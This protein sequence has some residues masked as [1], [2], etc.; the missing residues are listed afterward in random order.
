MKM[1][2][3]FFISLVIC[4]LLGKAET[5]TLA[6]HNLAPY[7]SYA[8]GAIMSTVANEEFTGIAVDRV[9]CSF[10]K[11]G[12]DLNILV[13][14]WAR[15]QRLAESAEVDGFFA[16]SQNNYRDTYAVKTNII[17][18][19]KWK[20]YWL[21]SNSVDLS[22][23][24]SDTLENPPRIGAFLG[25]NMSRWL[26]DNGY[27]IFSRPNTTE[28]LAQLLIKKRIDVF[29]ANNLVAEEIF[30]QMGAADQISSA[31]VKDKPLYLY[32]VKRNL[33]DHPNFVEDFN[34]ELANCYSEEKP[35]EAN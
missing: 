26:E 20:W 3:L 28:Q 23:L 31:V 18:Q 19:Q 4:P 27:S 17:A 5:I 30:E 11:M 34:R 16:G 29:I 9:R 25:S 24:K 33:K 10:A 14:P 8:E 32:M 35:Q 1:R 7:G 21:K 13:V 12:I 22:S 15:A 6:T 2:H